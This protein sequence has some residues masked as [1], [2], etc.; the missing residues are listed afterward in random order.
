MVRCFSVSVARTELGFDARRLAAD[1]SSD[2]CRHARQEAVRELAAHLDLR[3]TSPSPAIVGTGGRHRR[4][5]CVG[6]AAPAFSALAA[7][8]LDSVV[9][10]RARRDR[11]CG[12]LLASF[13]FLA[14]TTSRADDS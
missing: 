11:R 7:Q 8:Q 6:R 1:A 14:P 2:G 10:W 5:G 3:K 12:P 4:A 13:G 9:P